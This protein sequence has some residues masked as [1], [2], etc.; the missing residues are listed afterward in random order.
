[1]AQY[2]SFGYTAAEIKTNTGE[3]FCSPF[4]KS[5]TQTRQG[6]PAWRDSPA[7]DSDHQAFEMIFS[8]PLPHMGYAPCVRWERSP[9]RQRSVAMGTL[10]RFA[11]GHQT[12]RHDHSVQ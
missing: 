1:M 12:G 7:P 10:P 4:P 9:R 2:P 3:A 5:P 6:A 8:E 11:V